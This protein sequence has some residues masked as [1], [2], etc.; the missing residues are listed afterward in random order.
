MANGEF[1]DRTGLIV[2][3][4]VVTMPDWNHEDHPTEVAIVTLNNDAYP[5]H[6]DSRGLELLECLD[7]FVVVRGTL[8]RGRS[9]GATLDVTSF[10]AGERSA[11]ATAEQ[12]DDGAV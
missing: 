3:E 2:I 5:I 12:P 1:R 6:L 10:D 7:E 9:G 4:G 11:T 8:R